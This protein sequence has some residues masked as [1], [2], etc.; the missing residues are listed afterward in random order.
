M[1]ETALEVKGREGVLAFPILPYTK[2]EVKDT[3]LVVSA[4][5]REKQ[6][7]AN[8]GTMRALVYN[9]IIGVSAGFSKE[10]EIQGVGYRASMEGNTLVLHVGFTHPVKLPMPDGIKVSV[11]KNTI[12]I[13]GTDKYLV[14][15]I[16][17]KIRAVKKPEPYQGKGIR[18]KGEIV[19]RKAGKKVAGATAGAK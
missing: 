13:S 2:V 11:A 6:A 14:G 5:G 8:W 18:Y 19:M 9:M 4:S 16:T 1:G 10:L 15:Q 12:K 17:A 7:R 3:Q